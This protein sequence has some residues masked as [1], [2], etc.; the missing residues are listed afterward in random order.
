[1]IQK[2]DC[3]TNHLIYLL[4]DDREDAYLIKNALKGDKILNHS[5]VTF[6]S[7]DALTKALGSLTPDLIIMDLN[8]PDSGGF[9]TMITAKQNAQTVPIVVV[10]GSEEP[11]VGDQLIQLGAQDY[12]PKSELTSSLLQRVIRFSKERHHLLQLLENSANRD[13]LTKLYSR[14][15]LLLKVDELIEHAHRYD[16]TFALLFVDLD[17]FKPVNDELGHDA[18]DQ[19]L[20]HVSSRL[21]MFSRSTDFVSRY[22]GDEFVTVLP[23]VKNIDDAERAAQS[24]LKSICDAYVVMDS[25][26]EAQ[27]VQISASLGIAIY[28]MHGTT[29]RELIKAADSAMYQAKKSKS[30]IAV[31][32]CVAVLDTATN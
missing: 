18:G 1:M 10:T 15:A 19:L 12:I 29:G 8:L 3:K 2:A 27:E 16:E 7:L 9:N 28:G 25:S 11:L 22:G 5:V 17:G 24:Q 23:H 14:K 21:T 6:D 26:G 20:R 31:A 32:P 13:P 4:E 30:S